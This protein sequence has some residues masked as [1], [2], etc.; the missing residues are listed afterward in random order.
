MNTIAPLATA[1]VLQ[2]TGTDAITSNR[3]HICLRRADTITPEAIDWLFPGWLA[4]GKFHLIAGRPGTGKTTISIKFAA[5]IS[6]GGLW[7]DGTPAE[8]GDVV[9]WSGED[10]LADTLV[11]RLLAHGAD[12]ARIHFVD[13]VNEG[14]KRRPF[15]PASDTGLLRQTLAML[16]N[17]KLLIIDPVI[18]VVSGDS[19]KGGDVRRGLQP[20][21]DLAETTGVA[22]LGI[23]HFNKG[24]ADADPLDRVMG[25]QAFGAVARVVMGVAGAGEDGGE[26]KMV[27][28]KSNIGPDDGGY[29]FTLEQTRVP[30]R[31]GHTA[32]TVHWS[33]PLTGSARTLLAA[34]E[35][36]PTHAPS[37]SA[38]EWLRDRLAFGSAAV[39][40]L[41]TEAEGAGH[42]WRTVERAKRTL[43]VQAKKSAMTGGWEWELPKAG[44]F[45]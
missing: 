14:A 31:D 37:A 42:A 28:I 21:A 7:P 22:V 5:T 12:M 32:Q 24:S 16:P 13:G 25:S 30:A 17:P 3:R 2:D 6:G 9:I 35:P 8:V 43:R 20:L 23:T 45:D 34:S 18:V 41:Q 4:A 10:G 40:E 38:V 33:G 11:P 1:P 27:R 39:V 26:R 19:H 15:A 29:A 44:V 36:V